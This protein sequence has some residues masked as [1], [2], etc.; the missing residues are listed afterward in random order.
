MRQ[1]LQLAQR[2]VG[3]THPNPAVGCVIVKDGKVRCIVLD[4]KDLQ[5]LQ[6][7]AS[8]F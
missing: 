6:K 1:A 5:Q 3:H 2:G 7:I 4:I 8:V